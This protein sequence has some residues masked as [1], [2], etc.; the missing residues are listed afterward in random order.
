M[1]AEIRSQPHPVYDFGEF[2]LDASRRLLFAKGANDALPVTPKII[3][4]LLLFIENEGELLTK[5]QLMAG[6]WPGRVVEEN[7]LTQLISVLRHVLGEEPGENR[8]VATVPGFG[9]RF[10]ADVSRH[11]DAAEPP[12]SSQEIAPTRHTRPRRMAVVALTGALGA[13]LLTYGWYAQWRPVDEAPAPPPP[14][15]ELPSRTVAVLPFE[16]LS[17]DDGN[18]YIAFGVAESVLHRLAKIPN[19]TVIARTSSF[20][21]RDRAT[22][23]R[24]I[25]RA[26]NA[27]YLLEG[28][29]QHANERV[30]VIAQLIDATTGGH[31]W[32]LRFDRTLADIFSVE[33]EIAQGVAQALQVSL[34]QPEHPYARFG[35]DAYLSYLQGQT[36]LATHRSDDAER[37]IEHFRRAIEI[38]PNFGAGHAALADAMWQVLLKVQT[39][40]MGELH[41]ARTAREQQLLE[42]GVREVQPV[43]ERALELDD[44]LAEAYI[45][46]ADLKN[47]M[48][49]PVGAEAD[50]RKGLSLRPNYSKG[51][52]HLSILLY[53]LVGREEETLAEL[54]RAILL[55]PLMPRAYYVKGHYEVF[56]VAE[57]G[58]TAIEGERYIR[59]ALARAPDYHPALLL[60]GRIRWYQG[61]FAEAAMLAERALAVDP[62]VQWT[63]R[64]LAEIY[65][66]VGELDASRSV[67]L[68]APAT[69]PPIYWLAT[70]LYE[71][72]PE[73]AAE[74]L[75][76]DPAR[77]GFID[78]DT[79]AY[80]LRDAAKASGHP[81]HGLTELLKRGPDPYGLYR[82]PEPYALMTVAHLNFVL[83]DRAESERNA[84][85]LLEPDYD[86]YGFNRRILAVPK[87]AALTLLGDHDAAIDLLED[88]G[89]FG[90]GWRWWYT[91]DRDPVFDALRA[92]PRF[93]ALAAEAHAHAEAERERLRIMRERGQVPTRLA[94]GTPGPQ[95][96]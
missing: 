79:P 3:A 88:H 95:G 21:F 84:R 9:Y 72:R 70:C 81:E 94:D 25:G 51:H 2:R 62:R 44:R 89:R 58:G 7:S 39:A 34:E 60:L 4:A 80:V 74:L 45:L 11:V 37:A 67:L 31:V 15:I 28:S 43:L 36:L 38:A 64:V 55:D 13:V 26:L 20:V 5:D 73:Q 42:A 30:R 53:G 56:T 78:A 41:R 46:R 75:R 92:D 49:D 82:G 32:S 91:F 12:V 50:Y 63:R 52:L 27:R 83:G 93:Q 35:I 77:D 85:R 40:G 18:E 29:L 96:C 69:V 16:N 86:P 33:D 66:D 17:A 48:D 68:E 57:E 90:F 87:A 19:L 10:I 65:L 61:R 54:E 1:E 23:A 14:A 59:Q 24:D 8:Y 6:L 22:D 71:Q 76:A 47:V